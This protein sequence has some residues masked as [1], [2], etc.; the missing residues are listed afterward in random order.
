MKIAVRYDFAPNPKSIYIYC[1]QY[2]KVLEVGLIEKSA[3][4]CVVGTDSSRE[5]AMIAKQ[6][7]IK[8]I[9]TV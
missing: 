2:R 7:L 1:L 4:F 6:L 3:S 5:E 8:L 9:A